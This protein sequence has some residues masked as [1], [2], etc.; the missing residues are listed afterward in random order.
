MKNMDEPKSSIDRIINLQIVS[1]MCLC[2][3]EKQTILEEKIKKES[4]RKIPELETLSSC[5]DSDELEQIKENLRLEAEED[6]HES[7]SPRT[8]QKPWENSNHVK[9]L[10]TRKMNRFI[11]HASRKSQK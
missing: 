9:R 6:T 10:S 5:S 1:F 8:S 3:Q 7:V 2:L 11:R 4:M